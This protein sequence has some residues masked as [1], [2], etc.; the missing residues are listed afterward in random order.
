MARAGGERDCGIRLFLGRGAGGF[1]VS[2]LECPKTSLYIVA[3]RQPKAG[4]ELY[5]K[6]MTAFTSK[7]PPKQEYLATVKNTNYLPNVLMAREAA[8]R[9]MDCAVTFHEDGTMERRRRTRLS[10]SEPYSGGHEHALRHEGGK[11]AHARAF[12]RSHQG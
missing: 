8:E 2:P 4:E 10:A 1:G 11:G 9:G 6:G 5:E 7:V 3:V 12:C